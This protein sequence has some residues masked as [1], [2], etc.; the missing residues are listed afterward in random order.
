MQRRSA[1]G[2]RLT[3]LL[4]AGLV[5]VTTAPLWALGGAASA[6]A[7]PA[8][9]PNGDRVDYVSVIEVSGLLDP[10]LVDFVHTELRDAEAHRATALV[11]QL[12][13]PGA[14][15]SDATL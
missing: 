8:S 12:N 6:G 3:T 14:V 4:R 15:V 9:A 7:E 2:P 5:L 1:P 13:S 11:L 10:I